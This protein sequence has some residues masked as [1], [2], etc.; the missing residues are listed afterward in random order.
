MSAAVFKFVNV[1]I[2]RDRDLPGSKWKHFK[3]QVTWEN[4][5]I[6]FTTICIKICNEKVHVISGKSI[7]RCFLVLCKYWS[8]NIAQ[9]MDWIIYILFIIIIKLASFLLSY[10]ILCNENLIF[11]NTHCWGFYYLAF[12]AFYLLLRFVYFFA[13][14]IRM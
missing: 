2:T 3:Y 13:V 12:Y 1:Y 11:R 6:L 8:F 10:V 9:P 4:W 7:I 5:R 14:G